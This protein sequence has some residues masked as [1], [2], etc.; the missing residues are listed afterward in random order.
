M[1]L[2]SS[3]KIFILNFNILTMAYFLSFIFVFLICFN[4]YKCIDNLP[5]TEGVNAND[6]ALA[7]RILQ[8]S[9][10]EGYVL[11]DYYPVA[12]TG[13][14]PHRWIAQFRRRDNVYRQDCVYLTDV[15][16]SFKQECPRGAE[17]SQV[18][19]CCS[20]TRNFIQIEFLVNCR[21]TRVARWKRN[22]S[23]I[24]HSFMREHSLCTGFRN[25]KVK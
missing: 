8:Q 13:R 15:R 17:I 23:S 12:Q 4:K 9:T 7:E 14:N 16:L 19:V 2:D 20:P 22:V 6:M 11:F 18:Q 10:P 1:K 25:N 5:C 3:L 24:N 21:C